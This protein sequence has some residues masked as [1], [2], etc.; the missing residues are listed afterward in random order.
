MVEV[1][2]SA[3]LSHKLAGKA[4]TAYQLKVDELMLSAVSLAIQEWRGQDDFLIELESHGRHHDS[5]D[6]SQTVGWFT[7]RY[8]VLLASSAF[9]E[10]QD[11]LRQHVLAIKDQLRNVPNH[12]QGFGV[13]KY[14]HK[15]LQR[16]PTPAMVFNYL[17][18]NR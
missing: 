17:V 13:L 9:V 16:V 4:L 2:L 6:L 12:G 5:L 1:R 11:A 15:E 14:L 3:D 7:S 8:P 18:L 10:S